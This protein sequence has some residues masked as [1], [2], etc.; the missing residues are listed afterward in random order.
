MV[1]FVA[2]LRGINS[3]LNPTI[4]M[5]VLRNAFE[6]MGFRNVKTVIA[7]GNVLFD[8]DSTNE[9]NIEKII[10]KALPQAIGFE[11]A[12]I[13]YKVDDLQRLA[14]LNPFKDIEATPQTK[15]YVTFLKEPPK[16][17]PKISGKGFKILGT[18]G[19]AVFSMVDLSGAKTPDLMKVLE[20]EFG[21]NNTTRGWKT[22][23][24]ILIS[25]T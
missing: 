21:K 22:I 4:K 6:V 5:D 18:S 23:E 2:F 9:K 7:S 25:S 15:P 8:A 16:N 24:R 13:V 20:K 1:T 19:R 11:S 14:D 10:E 3:G 12:T 17:N